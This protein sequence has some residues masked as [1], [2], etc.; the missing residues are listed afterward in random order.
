VWLASGL[1]HHRTA[2]GEGVSIE[3]MDDLHQAIG[4]WLIAL[5]KLLN[6]AHT[7]SR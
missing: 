1:T 5:P 3:N 6:D 7:K 2:Y 4:A